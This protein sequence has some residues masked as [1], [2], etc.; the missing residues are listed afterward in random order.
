MRILIF[1]AKKTAVKKGLSKSHAPKARLEKI[2]S[3]EHTNY[4][5][6]VENLEYL[7]QASKILS[8]SLDYNKTINNVTKLLVPDMADWCS[9]SMLTEDNKIEQLAVAHIDPKQVKWAKALNKK[10][11][12]Q[13][14]DPKNVT[15]RVL[16]TA[17]SEFY[18]TIT[19]EMMVA[20]TNTPEQLK[21]LRKLN[22]KSIMIVPLIVQGKAIGT[23]SFISTDKNHLYGKSDLIIAEEIASRAALA[24]HNASLFT[25]S[26]QALT[27]RDE[28]ISIASHELKT[29]ITSLKMYG[30]IVHQQLQQLGVDSRILSSLLKMNEQV[31]R[32]TLLV[33]DMLNVSKIQLGKLEFH[34]DYFDIQKMVADTVEIVQSSA[35][36]HHIAI[37]GHITKRVWG[38][39]DRIS[40][41]L[42]NLLTNAIKY[43]P[44][45][46]KIMVTLTESKNDMVEIA[47]RD[48]GI[49]IDK[50]QQNKI[51]N[52]FYRVSGIN[53]KTFPG[54]GI[55]LY[56]SSEI[57]RRHHGSFSVVS[58]KGKGSTF[59][60]TIP[61]HKPKST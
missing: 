45:E 44:H 17:I 11:P 46:Y 23:I 20:N 58:A 27:L 25:Q 57:I 7:A 39:K 15:S 34:E 12:P 35:H 37:V 33:N 60:F 5:Q 38:D 40:Q 42:I 26:Q 9:V 30:Q 43:S 52:R 16:S 49:G 3:M 31:D 36:K 32:L 2:T 54:L 59:S 18:P 4:K 29:P 50:E 13:Y 24:I 47:V 22:L 8:S 55:G 6:L 28:F 41:V 48:Y 61:H 56:I 10:N 51:F 19:E 21:L 14:S 53:E 1:M